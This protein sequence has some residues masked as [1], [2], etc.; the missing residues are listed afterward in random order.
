MAQKSYKQSFGNVTWLV[1]DTSI[2][3]Y[4]L[5]INNQE[6]RSEDTDIRVH[7][8]ANQILLKDVNLIVYI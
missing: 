2:T 1:N 7:A 5:T 4:T 8:D 6:F 3:V